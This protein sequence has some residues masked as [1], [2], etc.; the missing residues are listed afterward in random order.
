M[1]TKQ[2]FAYGLIAVVLS[3]TFTVCKKDAPVKSDPSITQTVKETSIIT[4]DAPRK[5]DLAVS[6]TANYNTIANNVPVFVFTEMVSV[7][8]GTFEMGSSNGDDDEMPVHAV[9][10]RSF[11]MGKYPVTQ[12]EWFEIMGTTVRQQLDMSGNVWEWCW[13]RDGDYSS[14]AQT[15]PR[16][17]L[18]PSYRDDYLG[19]RLVRNA[20]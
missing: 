20:Q 9:T 1:R 7:E 15:D 17:A 3:L 18:P 16:G 6:D 5:S 8:G 2:A 11:S 19:F 10:V 4:H 12:K 14:G 13:D